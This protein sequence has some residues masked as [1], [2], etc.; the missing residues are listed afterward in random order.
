MFLRCSA[1]E[2]TRGLPDLRLILNVT[3]MGLL[4]N[5]VMNSWL[6]NISCLWYFPV[7]VFYVNGRFHCLH[8]GQQITSDQPIDNPTTDID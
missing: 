4:A 2:V 8:Y 1:A 6:G 5:N 7:S 3:V